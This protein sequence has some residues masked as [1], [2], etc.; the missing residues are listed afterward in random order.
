MHLKF[1]RVAVFAAA[2]VWALLGL[3][4]HATA[5]VTGGQ[6]ARPAV[7]IEPDAFWQARLAQQDRCLAELAQ[8]ESD[9]AALRLDLQKR[10]EW[11]PETP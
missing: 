2:C 10:R 1:A 6:G 11:L 8:L 5:L 9:L 7:P 3:P 4:A